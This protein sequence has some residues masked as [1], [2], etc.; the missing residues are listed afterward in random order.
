M[1]P[2]VSFFSSASVTCRKVVKRSKIHA[3]I[4]AVVMHYTNAWQNS[5]LQHT[6]LPFAKDSLSVRTPVVHC[7]SQVTQD[8]SRLGV[9]PMKTCPAFRH[10]DTAVLKKK[11]RPAAG[12]DFFSWYAILVS[13][14]ATEMPVMIFFVIGGNICLGPQI[15]G[16][17]HCFPTAIPNPAPLKNLLILMEILTNIRFFP[18]NQP[19]F[20]PNVF[21][22]PAITGCSFVAQC[23]IP[24]AQDTRFVRALRTFFV[25]RKKVRCLLLFYTAPL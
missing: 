8:A 17:P 2:Q 18:K 24:L 10:P 20:F 5:N 23:E 16:T 25:G 6:F 1:E 12:A 9:F 13:H 15:T 14:C 7:E 3:A 19:F 4:R 22:S 11:N 21:H